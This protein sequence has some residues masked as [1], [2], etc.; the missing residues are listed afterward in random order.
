[1]SEQNVVP[2]GKHKGKLIEELIADDPSYLEWLSGQDWFRAKYV[3]LHQ[4]IIN[5]GAA[6]EETPEHNALQVKFLDDDFCLRFMR[7]LI[8]DCEAQALNEFNEART[9]N[10]K[11]ILKKIE[12]EEKAPQE[13]DDALARQL[14]RIEGWDESEKIRWGAD[15]RRAGAQ[16]RREKQRVEHGKRLL[17]LQRLCAGLKPLFANCGRWSKE[18]CSLI[19][20][21]YFTTLVFL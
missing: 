2:F 16:E 20:T 13:D 11:L 17:H 5:R 15:N 4:I 9:S 3:N 21:H 7:H 18:L 19:E 1:M 10:L 12:E 6:P 8:P 14:E